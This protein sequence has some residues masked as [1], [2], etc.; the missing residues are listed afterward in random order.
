MRCRP[1]PQGPGG[2]AALVRVPVVVVAV[3]LVVVARRRRLLGAPLAEA[4]DR[5]VREAG[6]MG[7]PGSDL[8]A[9][10]VE[11]LGSEQR[12]LGAALAVQVLAVAADQR[13]QAGAVPEVHVPREAL[14]FEQLEVAIHRGFVKGQLE[15]ELLGRHR[16]D[17]FR[18]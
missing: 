3:V 17:E 14:A 5:E 10:R 18:R 11:L 6:V 1:G 12:H 13:V 7:E 2:P 16:P 4:H 9:D 15:R 8:G